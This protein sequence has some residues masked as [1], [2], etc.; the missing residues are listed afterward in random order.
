MFNQRTPLFAVALVVGSLILGACGSD[1]NA[2]SSDSTVEVTDTSPAA[3]IGDSTPI[4]DTAVTTVPSGATETS[5]DAVDTTIV[6]TE[7][8][9]VA[10]ETS[11]AG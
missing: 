6:A 1:D 9:I 3:S 8:T 4:N 11:V 7:T 2:D 5:V 10:T